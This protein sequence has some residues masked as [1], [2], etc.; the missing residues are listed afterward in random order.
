LRRA[1]RRVEAIEGISPEKALTKPLQTG[2]SWRDTFVDRRK[3]L[4]EEFASLFLPNTAQPHIVAVAGLLDCTWDEAVERINE[5]S[6]VSL[7]TPTNRAF[8]PWER[9]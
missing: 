6:L 3:K 7:A 1:V 4:V 2:R 5:A 8:P 9:A